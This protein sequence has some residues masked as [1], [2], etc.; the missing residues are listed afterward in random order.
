MTPGSITSAG[1]ACALALALVGPAAAAPTL[2]SERQLGGGAVRYQEWRHD[3]PT[4]IHLVL[5]DLSATEITVLA[6]PQDLAG[7]TPTELSQL[8]AAPVVVNGDFFAVVGNRPRGLARGDMVTWS[9]TADSPTSGVLSLSHPG[10]SGVIARLYAPEEPVDHQAWTD[11]ILAAVS[12]KPMLVRGNALEPPACADA[13][14]LACVRAP[15]TAIGLS[16]DRLRLL[17]AVVDGWQAGQAGLTAAELGG[18]L[19]SQGAANA[20]GLGT[21]ASAAMVWDGALISRP[22]DGVERAVAN[23]LAVRLAPTTLVTLRGN[24]C[25][26]TT[27]PC[28]PIADAAVTL[29]GV[30]TTTS[31]ATGGFEFTDVPARRVCVTAAKAGYRTG[32]QCKT[33]DQINGLQFNSVVLYPVGDPFDAAPPLADAA[34]NPAGDAGVTTPPGAGC[35]RAGPGP[36]PG[37]AALMLLVAVGLRRRRKTGASP[38]ASCALAV[39]PSS[40]HP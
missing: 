27:M 30:R 32:Q 13:E 2:V 7:H 5:V 15:R 38:A 14:T 33:L 24:V 12:G 17:V 40:R 35:C 39:V 19:Q 22:S 10:A 28:S 4:T 21:G 6:T 25:E 34:G 1:L 23:H 36:G 11:D 9:G 20:L 18:F 16:A 37:P 8:V 26:R 3:A 29:D 31:N